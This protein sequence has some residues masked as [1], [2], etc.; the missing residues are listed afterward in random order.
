MST[1]LDVSVGSRSGPVVAKHMGFFSSLQWEHELRLGP[2]LSW[3][4]RDAVANA[5][6]VLF[7]AA[8][9]PVM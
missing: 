4:W 3:P 1:P 7:L 5:A 8:P 9:L 6:K 2:G